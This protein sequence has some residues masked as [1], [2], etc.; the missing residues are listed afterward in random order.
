MK[1]ALIDPLKVEVILP[2]EAYGKIKTGMTGQVIPEGLG[3]RYP[4]SVKIVDRVFD[5]ASGTFGVRLE[6]PNHKGALPGGIRCQVEFAALKG[7][8]P[9]PIKR[10]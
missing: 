5:A 9:R 8:E 2:L 1:L 7:V 6:L 10:K 3:G 4:A